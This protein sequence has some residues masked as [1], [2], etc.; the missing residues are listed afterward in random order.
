ME[1]SRSAIA[2][3]CQDGT[4]APQQTT[5]LIGQLHPMLEVVPGKMPSGQ[6]VVWQLVANKRRSKITYK[7]RI[8]IDEL[9]PWNWRRHGLPMSSRNC[10]II[11][12][13]VVGHGRLVGMNALGSKYVGADQRHERHQGC[14]A[15]AD[16]IRER[17]DIQMYAFAR[18]GHALAVGAQPRQRSP[19]SP[20]SPRRPEPFSARVH[21]RRRSGPESTVAVVMGVPLICQLMGTQAHVRISQGR[22]CPPDAYKDNTLILF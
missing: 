16:P 14:S 1:C 20:G 10:R 21:R 4:H 9:L 17:R 8:R 22:W 6:V 15:G 13:N 7:L 2:T 3:V 18:I 5:S 11:L 12:P 19:Q